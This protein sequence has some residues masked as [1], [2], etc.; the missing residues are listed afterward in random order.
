MSPINDIKIAISP[1]KFKAIE[2]SFRRHFDIALEMSDAEG[3]RIPKMCSDDC[4]PQFCRMINQDDAGSQRCRHFRLRSLKIAFETGQPYICI[5]HAGIVLVCVPVMEKETPLGGFFFGKCLWEKVDTTMTGDLF[6]HLQGLNLD[7]EKIISAAKRLQIIKARTI[8]EAAE[9]LFVLIYEI[10]QLDPRVIQW[11]KTRTRQ[12]SEISSFIHQS[13]DMNLTKTYPYEMERE[14][15]SKVKIGDRTG[16]VK[17]LNTFLGTI[18]FHYPGDTTVLKARLVELLGV[19]SRAAVEG[20]VDVDIMLEKNLTY[21]NKVLNVDRQDDICLWI[22]S[23]LNDFIESVYALSAA[24][25]N[26]K[27]K[28]VINF[29]EANFDRSVTLADMA[30]VAHLSVSRFAHLFKEQMKMTPIDYLTKA[31]IRYAKDRLISTE[32]NCTEISFDCGY[33][34]QSY[35]NR[36][37]KQQTKM[38]PLQ[39]RKQNKR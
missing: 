5:C 6:K 24:Q 15:I 20:G 2:R 8:H 1:A 26:L 32:D 16:A 19:L 22:S 30:K 27:L 3:T 37:F 18:M 33:N 9:F 11:R 29:I 35:F 13:K 39:F 12:Q 10:S 7:V 34:N 25:K 4:A 23:A 38:T 31:R 21:I 14:L 36:I 17:I 28:P